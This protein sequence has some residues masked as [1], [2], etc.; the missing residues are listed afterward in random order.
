MFTL[1]Y[2]A[3]NATVNI[4]DTARII[5]RKYPKIAWSLSYLE[6]IKYLEIQGKSPY[7]G[8][9]FEMQVKLSIFIIMRI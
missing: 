2:T 5:L 4:K 6:D 7:E 8:I 9:P 1:N 3:S